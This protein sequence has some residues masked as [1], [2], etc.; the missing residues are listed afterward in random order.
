M[1]E[2]WGSPHDLL[3]TPNCWACHPQLQDGDSL[4]VLTVCAGL[5]AWG[6]GPPGA[7]RR[8]WCWVDRYMAYMARRL[9]PLDG[10][11][12]IVHGSQ[13]ATLVN[14]TP[15][16]IWFMVGITI[17]NGVYKM[18]CINGFLFRK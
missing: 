13:I 6:P 14:I 12:A 5:P 2:N 9:S 10:W 11:L 18:R 1:D 3:G 15:R 7:P 4:M 17:V 16:T 8:A